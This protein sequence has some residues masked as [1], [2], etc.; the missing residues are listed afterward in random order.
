MILMHGAEQ[1]SL[2][3]ASLNLLLSFFLLL[4]GCVKHPEN[5]SPVRDTPS[6]LQ[7]ASPTLLA[8]QPADGAGVKVG[9]RVVEMPA[10]QAKV[11]LN[12][13][14][15]SSKSTPEQVLKV[16]EINLDELVDRLKNTEAIGLFT[17]LAIRSDVLDFKTSIDDYRKKGELEHNIAHLRDHFDGLVLKILALLERDPALSKD[18]HQ[19]RESIW[20]SFL[21]AK[22]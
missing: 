15:S 6:G 7:S 11:V 13:P 17:K 9:T 16:P 20:R 4:T 10:T 18:I 12:Q 19:A 22:S 1:I 3:V 14:V 8:G 2:K 5:S 21:E